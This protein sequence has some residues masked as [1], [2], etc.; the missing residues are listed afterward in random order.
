MFDGMTKVNKGACSHLEGMSISRRVD[1][2]LHV[3]LL[4]LNPKSEFR[5]PKGARAHRSTSGFGF[6]SVF[7]LRIS[8]LR[9]AM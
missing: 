3:L 6:D 8:G 2:G 9:R 5:N 7:G 1:R 4:R